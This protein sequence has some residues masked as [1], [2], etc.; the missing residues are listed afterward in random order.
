MFEYLIL[1]YLLADRGH[2][3]WL[4]NT[5][6]NTYSR[7]HIRINPDGSKRERYRFWNFSFH[8]LGMDDLPSMIDYILSV[9]KD[10]AKIHY[11]GHSQGT[12]A[13]FVMASERPEY[14]TK[15]QLMQAF[16]PVAFMNHVENF[17][18]HPAATYLDSLNVRIPV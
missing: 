12:T 5:R 7:R 6:G 8:Q 4:A 2:D 10:F 11:I 1:A 13:F 15:I 3:V 14:N 18:V 17:F 9:N 16:A